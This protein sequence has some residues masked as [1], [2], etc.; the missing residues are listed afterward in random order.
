MTTT[1]FLFFIYTALG[2]PSFSFYDPIP[3]LYEARNIP[4][5][6]KGQSQEESLAA[7]SLF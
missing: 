6:M 2:K 3:P 1:Y 5:T 4:T 7:G